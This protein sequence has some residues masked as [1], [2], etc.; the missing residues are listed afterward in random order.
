MSRP[1]DSITGERLP[2]DPR[3]GAVQRLHHRLVVL[4]VGRGAV[5][6]AGLDDEADAL[7][8]G[9]D[10]VVGELEGA[11]I[12]DAGRVV[13]V[14]LA[15]AVVV[16]AVVAGRVVLKVPQQGPDVDEEA[17]GLEAAEDGLEVAH[18][19]GR[20]VEEE[21]GGDD[22]VGCAPRLVAV[23]TEEIGGAHGH[24]EGGAW[25]QVWHGVAAQVVL[26]RAVVREGVNPG[27]DGEL[28]GGLGVVE[29]KVRGEELVVGDLVALDVTA[30]AAEFE[31][32]AAETGAGDE[33]AEICA[34]VVATAAAAACGGK[35]RALALDGGEDGA[36]GG[37]A[38]GGAGGG[39]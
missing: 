22:V 9:H 34:A 13:V 32:E 4:D 28:A 21:D 16:A 25:V 14:V 10:L 5:R 3:A 38:L 27:E 35:A 12:G 30:G 6:L 29:D 33:D 2:R 11:R 17:A 1:L 37:V 18:E 24:G 23:E 15:V 26:A 36:I 8:E 20:R 19:V 7:D 39:P 31:D